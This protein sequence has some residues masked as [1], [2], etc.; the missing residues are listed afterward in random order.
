MS[1][2]LK[3]RPI[4]PNELYANWA[5]Y[6]DTTFS[7]LY[8]RLNDPNSA[9][10]KL[11]AKKY[12]YSTKNKLHTANPRI[13]QFLRAVPGEPHL[14][15]LSKKVP[16]IDIH[17]SISD[18]IFTSTH[19]MMTLGEKEECRLAL[20]RNRVIN[21]KSMRMIS[22]KGKKSVITPF[23]LAPLGK[24]FYREFFRHSPDSVASRYY[25]QTNATRGFHIS[26]IDYLAAHYHNAGHE[27]IKGA[28]PFDL[29]IDQ[30]HGFLVFNQ[31]ENSIGMEMQMSEALFRAIRNNMRLYIPAQ[32]TVQEADFI[33]AGRTV[34]RHSTNHKVFS[35]FLS[36]GFDLRGCECRW[37]GQYRVG[38]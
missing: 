11:G 5:E 29:L 36:G 35:G 20:I 9:E 12:F 7:R 4:G 27:V 17:S 26:H 15:T 38:G 13:F 24:H 3:S 19:Y 6:S 33:H 22:S 14:A 10:K 1:K 37:V 32:S 16:M 31:Y 8:G 18:L 21:W 34:I 30:K 25:P 23:F 2:N 28:Y